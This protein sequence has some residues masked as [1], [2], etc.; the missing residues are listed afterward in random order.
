M[1][2]V[3]RRHVLDA[4]GEAAGAITTGVAGDI[5]TTMQKFDSARRHARIEP[6]SDRRVLNGHT[7]N[8]P[9]A[10]EEGGHLS[11]TRWVHQTVPDVILLRAY[12]V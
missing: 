11:I 2:V 6:E 3:R 10:N 7:K 9:S 8:P 5:A 4:G 1:A 12:C